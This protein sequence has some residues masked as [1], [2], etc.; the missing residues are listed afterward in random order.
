MARQAKDIVVKMSLNDFMRENLEIENTEKASV[1]FTLSINQMIKKIHPHV[2]HPDDFNLVGIKFRK[3][4]FTS[5]IVFFTKMG[6]ITRMGATY[7]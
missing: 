7:S 6:G 4:Y 3:L 2:Q 1:P 5:F